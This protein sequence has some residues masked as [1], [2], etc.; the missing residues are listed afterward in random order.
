MSSRVNIRIQLNQR[1]LSCHAFWG[2]GEVLPFTHSVKP[3][4][5]SPFHPPFFTPN[6]LTEC[7]LTLS[8]KLIFHS[9]N[10]MSMNDANYDSD[11]EELYEVEM[12]GASRMTP[13]GIQYLVKWLHFSWSDAT[14][15]DASRLSSA[16]L[17]VAEF[18]RLERK[19]GFR[20]AEYIVID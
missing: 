18:K 14:W 3:V 8:Y 7:L 13:H 17:A 2:V 6:P 16:P 15:E 5:P 19:R 1:S 11:V 9:P 20:N 12:V 10:N 4:T